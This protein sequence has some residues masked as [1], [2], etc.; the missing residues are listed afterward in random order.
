MSNLPTTIMHITQ[1][2]G[3]WTA[4]SAFGTLLAAGIA[5]FLPTYV[6][7]RAARQARKELRSRMHEV[8]SATYNAID[9]LAKA[10]QSFIAAPGSA[11]SIEIAAEASFKA[12]TL[13]ILANIP[14]LGDGSIDCA[15]GA[16]QFLERVV[17]AHRLALAG[18][19]ANTSRAQAELDAAR[20][21]GRAV[22]D[23]IGKVVAYSQIPV[24]AGRLLPS[25]P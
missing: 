8:A 3:E 7:G 12:D 15:V 16:A 6:N 17:E 20:A 23:R 24:R 18:G 25:R 9:L 5:L 22:Y 2:N 10:D 21:I 14:Q 4:W 11:H 13:R 19:T 1:T